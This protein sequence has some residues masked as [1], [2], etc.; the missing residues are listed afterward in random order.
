LWTGIARTGSFSHNGSGDIFLAV[1]TQ[2]PV[3]AN[4][5]ES[6]DIWKSVPKE[7]MD[8]IYEATVDATGEAIINVLVAGVTMKGINGNIV[9]A[10]PTDRLVALMK[11]YNRMK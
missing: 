7:Y 4:K 3:A 8:P 1:S 6:L 2:G 9:Y 10:L 11:K 5:N